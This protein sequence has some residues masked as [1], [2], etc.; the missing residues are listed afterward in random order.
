MED[1]IGPKFPDQPHLEDFFSEGNPNPGTK[2]IAVKEGPCGGSLMKMESQL[3]ERTIHKTTDIR[4]L[5]H[6]N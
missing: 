4:G 5:K 2:E 3:M 1:S 6:C